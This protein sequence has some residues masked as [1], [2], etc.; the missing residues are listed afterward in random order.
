[1]VLSG[2]EGDLAGYLA[3]AR[4]ELA[5]STVTVPKATTANV[6]GLAACGSMRGWS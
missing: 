5:T 1:M 2:G 4:L 6:I 3:S